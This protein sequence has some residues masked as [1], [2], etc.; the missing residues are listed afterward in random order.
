MHSFLNVKHV[1]LEWRIDLTLFALSFKA[2]LHLKI[3][4][5]QTEAAR[6][7]EEKLERV[8]AK[9]F[10]LS[11]L[12][13]SADDDCAQDVPLLKA[14]ERK[15][16]CEICKVRLSSYLCVECVQRNRLLAHER[17]KFGQI[18]SFIWANLHSSLCIDIAQRYLVEWNQTAS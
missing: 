13:C 12:R 2:E 11:V 14:Y 10:E 17:R 5:K 1:I 16:K 3:H 8:R 6:R 15:K 18:S 4:Q 9:A 7:H